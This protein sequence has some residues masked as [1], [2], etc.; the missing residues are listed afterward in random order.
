MDKDEIK[1]R[2][3]SL[4][5]YIESIERGPE[6]ALEKLSNIDDPY[7]RRRRLAVLINVGRISEAAGLVRETPSDKEWYD[8]A[9][10]ALAA[11]GEFEAA[12]KHLDWARST[13]DRQILDRAAV[14][15]SEGVLNYTI[16]GRDLKK[17]LSASE[18]TD[19]D[20]NHLLLALD[21]VEYLIARV[22]ATDEAADIY[23]TGAMRIA[24]YSLAA[25]SRLDEAAGY[26]LRLIEKKPIPVDIVQ[27]IVDFGIAPSLEMVRRLRQEHPDSAQAVL[28]AGLIEG[29]LL[30]MRENA[31]ESIIQA[32]NSEWRD[33]EREAAVELML[34]FGER[35]GVEALRRVED[36]SKS[37]LNP[38]NPLL[39]LIPA[40]TA[41]K[42]GDFDAARAML[43]RTEDENDPLW[44]QLSSDLLANQ[45]NNA[46]ALKRI[47]KAALMLHHPSIFLKTAG[48]AY[49][50][51]RLDIAAEML[52]RTIRL[53]PGDYRLR[54][55][56]AFTF[57]EQKEYARAA[58]EFGFLAEAQPD[59]ITHRVNQAACLM[60]SGNTDE[61]LRVYDSVCREQDPPLEAILGRAHLLR[62]G[63]R[64]QDAMKSMLPFR[65]SFWLRPE[66]VLVLFE[67]AF[68]AGDD[69]LGHEAGMRL[70]ELQ[71]QGIAPPGLVRTVETAELEE[72][73]KD[74]RELTKVVSNL[75]R[76]GAIPWTLADKR[77]GISSYIGWALR[78]QS[79][80]W[81][82]DDLLFRMSHS[83]YATN[84]YRL[85]SDET[86]RSTLLSLECP[87]SNTMVCADLSALISLHR[88]NLL[89]NAIDYFGLV[90]IPNTYLAH[91]VEEA[92]SLILHQQS[93]F[94]DFQIIREAVESRRISILEEPGAVGQRVMPYVNEHTFPENDREHF[95]RLIDIVR[96]MHNAGLLSDAVLRQLDSIHHNAS[97]IDATHPAVDL[98]QP[99]LVA[100]STLSSLAHLGIFDASVKSFT[101]HLKR[102][103]WEEVASGIR[104][105]T[106]QQN[107][108]SWHR[109]LWAYVKSEKRIVQKPFIRDKGTLPD[110]PSYTWN[111]YLASYLLSNQ[112]SIPLLA[113]DRTIQRVAL[114][115]NRNAYYP[116]FG[117]DRLITALL[118]AKA[119]S[120]DDAADAFLKMIRWRYR[121]ILPPLETL[122][123][124]AKRHM[125]SPPG[126]D[127]REIASYVHDCMRDPGL[128]GS[129]ESTVPPMNI[130]ER[131]FMDWS[132]L[133]G[134]FLMDIWT[135]PD[136]TEGN[137]QTLTAWATRELAPSPPW[138][139]RA[140]HRHLADI[141][142]RIIISKALIRGLQ[143][144]NP[145]RANR[146]LVA[147]SD[148]FGLNDQQYLRIVTEAINAG[149]P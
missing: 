96:P 83:I 127:L 139:L 107:V 78:T 29:T 132:S 101:I 123:S 36:L 25:L 99:I 21:E 14:S 39:N 44:L 111:V 54:T 113:D 145:E 62:A 85:S 35:L 140:S 56:L 12:D 119:I 77:M 38:E 18:L 33:E 49:K 75:L 94:T 120:L 34:E 144:D 31:F 30:G 68:A 137:A 19:R 67:L 20:V 5:A 121:Y 80:P 60:Q 51:N 116:T 146:C 74:L 138:V 90:L 115:E 124:I 2:I 84:V 15:Y 22:R 42:R 89:P 103:Q 24:M 43:D 122:T 63:G 3:E 70:R 37:W 55:D 1:R 149:R 48:I 58:A 100:L 136:H 46:E 104:A 87:P 59:N 41:L 9:I 45:G 57:V 10:Y 8:K 128:P 147:I 28:L 142:A 13:R 148:A 143:K 69:R 61:S 64:P 133:V 109:D 95:Y 73:G 112:S 131:L 118:S 26:A 92:A 86:G 16:G 27:F 71:D 53:R 79:L 76:Q 117:T 66:Y 98:H 7:V 91:S 135:D 141:S 108:Q 50:C 114:G 52:E 97:G 23:E 6:S 72:M 106:A 126:S 134:E 130:A 105:I 4:D 102:S 125:T 65:E 17:V 81:L 32:L 40:V 88:L 129:W 82:P 93:Q 47:R 11:N 110:A